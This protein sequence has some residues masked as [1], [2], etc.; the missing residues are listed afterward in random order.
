MVLYSIKVHP[1]FLF[2]TPQPK[3]KTIGWN[4][5]SIFTGSLNSQFAMSKKNT[6]D[7]MC[8][9][10]F[11]FLMSV[12]FERERGGARVGAGEGQRERETQSTKQAPG[13]Q[14]RAQPRARTHGAWDHDLSWSQMLN[15]LSYP[16]ALGICF[17]IQITQYLVIW[18]MKKRNTGNQKASIISVTFIPTIPTRVIVFPYIVSFVTKSQV[19]CLS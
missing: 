1:Y 8:G 9:N 10:L 16:G 19:T 5:N 7:T 4:L 13:C 2:Q 17:Y 11:F 15:R 12:Y 18:L 14:H 3:E 6:G